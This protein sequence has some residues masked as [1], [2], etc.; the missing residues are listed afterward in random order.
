MVFYNLFLRPPTTQELLEEGIADCKAGRTSTYTVSSFKRRMREEKK[1]EK[2]HPVKHFIRECGWWIRHAFNETIEFPRNA[3]RTSR[4]GLQRGYRGW[5]DEDTWSLS[6]YTSK[7]VLQSLK[8]LKSYGILLRTGELYDY[9]KD[10]GPDNDPDMDFNQKESDEIV[11]EILWAWDITAKISE[12]RRY[13]YTVRAPKKE[14]KFLT[15][16]EER[17][18]YRGLLLWIKHFQSLSD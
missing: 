1:W 17:R 16:A 14:K 18:R 7:V 13:A 4:R 3:Y 9:K 8:H 6:W 15:L 11:K 2:A 5:A 10:I 12:G